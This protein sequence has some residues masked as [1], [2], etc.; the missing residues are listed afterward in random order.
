MFWYSDHIQ[1]MCYVY[2]AIVF[3]IDKVTVYN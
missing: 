2:S 3:A 1:K